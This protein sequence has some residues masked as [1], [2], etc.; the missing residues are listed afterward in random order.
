MAAS[1]TLAEAETQLAFVDGAMIGRAAYANPYLLAEADGRI[2]GE[3][4]AA[5]TREE[6]VAALQSYAK[7]VTER[8]VALHAVSR[9]ILGLFQGV[10]GG[11]AWRRHLSDAAHRPGAGPEVIVE[12]LSL[13][14]EAERRLELGRE[15]RAAP[16]LPSAA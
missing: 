6:I 8:G 2:F 11:K 14:L 15:K 13:A 9:H 7:G 3:S 12:A 5:P 10:P 4:R 1:Q 16:G